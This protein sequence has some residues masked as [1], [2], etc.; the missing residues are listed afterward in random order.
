M[1]VG[2]GYRFGRRVAAVLSAT[3][4]GG[5][6][7]AFATFTVVAPAGASGCAQAGTTGFTAAVVATQGQMITGTVDATGCN[8]GVYVGPGITGVTVSG[9]TV[10]NATDHG[11]LAEDTS[12]VTIQNNTVSNNGTQPNPMVA[13]DDAIFFSGVSG[14]T[15]SGNTETNDFAGGIRVTDDGPLDPAAPNPGPRP[16]CHP[17]TTPSRATSSAASTAAAPCSSAAYNSGNDIQSVTA[18]NNTIT[19]A[20]GQFGAHGP[21]IG[22]IV[23]AGDG[24]GGRHLRGR[25][26]R[27]H[28]H[29]E[30][31]DRHHPPRQRAR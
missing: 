25:R 20:I 15:I 19:G 12:N 16:S 30:H 9:A 18:S 29:P 13:S 24:P 6:M 31:P 21:V 23:I 3:S 11:I 28:G 27:E 5:G 10:E 8:L 4:M 17:R 26:E 22:Q 7:L 14:S 2:A 1:G